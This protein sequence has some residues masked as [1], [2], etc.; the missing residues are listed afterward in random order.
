MLDYKPGFLYSFISTV[1]TMKPTQFIVRSS[2]IYSTSSNATAAITIIH[3][4]GIYTTAT[5]VSSLH[6]LCRAKHQSKTICS[7]QTSTVQKSGYLAIKNLCWGGGQY[8]SSSSGYKLS[9]S[10]T[11]ISSGVESLVNRSIRY[12]MF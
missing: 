5:S 1:F 7:K 8:S 12:Y 2:I 3:I 11:L 4:H 10:A 6:L 9:L